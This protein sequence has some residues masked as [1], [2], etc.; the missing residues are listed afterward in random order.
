MI[1]KKNSNYK[2]NVIQGLNNQ[3]YY[4]TNIRFIS[5]SRVKNFYVPQF[6]HQT[7]I[8]VNEDGSETTGSTGVA[9]FRI[10]YS[11]F[12]CFIR[13]KNTEYKRFYLSVVWQSPNNFS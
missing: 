9:L 8:E 11:S 2:K 4:I 13:D 7:V 12:L 6:F 3:G 5:I 1:N 10:F